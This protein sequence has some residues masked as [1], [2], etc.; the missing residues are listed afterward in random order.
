MYEKLNLFVIFFTV[1]VVIAFFICWAPFH[2]Q[3]LMAIYITSPSDADIVAFS[4]L[5]NISGVLYYVSATINPILYSI[6][7]LKFRHAF[8]DTLGR[9][10]G[11]KLIRKDRGRHM[12]LYNSTLRSAGYEVTDLTLVSE[13]GNPETNGSKKPSKNVEFKEIVIHSGPLMR[14]KTSSTISNASLRLTDV[15]E[16]SGVSD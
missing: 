3:R 14:K 2:A 1:A 12:S 11:G 13:V 6:L 7:S 16:D 10:I 5:T 9:C 15:Y 8:R 4:Y